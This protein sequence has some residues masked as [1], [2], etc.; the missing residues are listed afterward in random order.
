VVPVKA[1]D[2]IF[3]FVNSLKIFMSISQAKIR[4]GFY[5]AMNGD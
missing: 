5:V 4:L 2:E 1:V 3:G